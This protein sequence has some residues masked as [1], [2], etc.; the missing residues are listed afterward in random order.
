MIVVGN[1]AHRGPDQF[2]SSQMT[3]SGMTSCTRLPPAL[4][5]VKN[6]T[7]RGRKWGP[8]PLFQQ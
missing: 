7:S 3:T 5:L 8:S 6:V 2:D 1:F 4:H